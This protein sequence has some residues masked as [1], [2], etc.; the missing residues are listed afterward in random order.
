MSKNMQL[1]QYLGEERGKSGI[2]H[3]DWSIEAMKQSYQSQNPDGVVRVRLYSPFFLM[4]LIVTI[5]NGFIAK[6]KGY[7][8]V[9]SLAKVKPFNVSAGFEITF[10]HFGP[11]EPIAS[12]IAVS[13][14]EGNP[15]IWWS[16]L[17]LRL[18]GWSG[19]LAL[20]IGT[21]PPLLGVLL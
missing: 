5:D 1:Y 8:S 10:N 18:T 21:V 6:R 19:P 14:L 7:H 15:H 16:R 12:T 4:S 3:R 9:T 11:V 20:C 2:C 17:G 13:L